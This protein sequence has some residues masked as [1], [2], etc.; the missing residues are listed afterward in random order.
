MNAEET[1]QAAIDKL[2]R[3]RG[4]AEMVADTLVGSDP[5]YFNLQSA[6][7][8]WREDAEL[9][10]TLHATIDAQLAILALA[11]SSYW[12]PGAAPEDWE[13]FED[14]RAV[15]DLARAILGEQTDD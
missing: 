8:L 12:S 6:Y 15:M 4:E 2:A 9:I 10:V 3:L 11:R 5:P 1:I 13:T 7:N 14:G